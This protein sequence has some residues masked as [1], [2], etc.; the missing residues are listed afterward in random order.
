MRR[1]LIHDLNPQYSGFAAGILDW[2]VQLTLLESEG[3]LAT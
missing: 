1:I 2:Q 3:L